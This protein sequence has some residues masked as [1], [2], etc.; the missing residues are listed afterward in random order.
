MSLRHYPRMERGGDVLVAVPKPFPESRG[1][2][3][4]RMFHV[5]FDS[6][7]DTD[8]DTDAGG[9]G[10]RPGCSSLL[11][12]STQRVADEAPS[13]D[14]DRRRVWRI[15]PLPPHG[16]GWRR[17][18]R[19][20][21]SPASGDEDIA[22]PF[23]IGEG[24]CE[25]WVRGKSGAHDLPRPACFAGFCIVSDGSRGGLAVLAGAGSEWDLCGD[26]LEFDVGRRGAGEGVDGECGDRVLLGGGFGGTVVH[27]GLGGRAGHGALSG[28]GHGQAAVEPCLPGEAGEQNV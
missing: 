6:D 9:K 18:R 22:T 8:P 13:R 15:V 26:G 19:P 27:G 17:P 5:V 28:R 12:V 10:S 21:Q 11:N 3:S 25:F 16:T 24:S 2:G 14:L 7:G 4:N 20:P 1:S 23:R